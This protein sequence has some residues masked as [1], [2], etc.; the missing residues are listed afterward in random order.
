MNF[1]QTA[2]QQIMTQIQELAATA[3]TKK[4]YQTIA[5]K[6]RFIDFNFK[7]DL[8]SSEI[9]SEVQTWLARKNE[10]DYYPEKILK[11]IEAT[12]NFSAEGSKNMAKKSYDAL[13]KSSDL[14][15]PTEDLIK[16]WIVELLKIAS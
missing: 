13:M 6:I 16:N 12:G 4:D 8:R 2:N 11:V 10:D 7:V 1:T 9:I 14:R 3:E 15:T 5:K